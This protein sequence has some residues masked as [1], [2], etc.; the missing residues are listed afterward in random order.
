MS[1]PILATAVAAKDDAD[2]GGKSVELKTVKTMRKYRSQTLKD[3]QIMIEYKHLKHHAPRGMYVLPSFTDR[4]CWHGVVFLRQGLYKRGIFK[5]IVSGGKGA[6]EG[7]TRGRRVRGEWGLREVSGTG[8]GR[9]AGCARGLWAER[10]GR[11]R[12]GEVSLVKSDEM[13]R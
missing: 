13:G 2:E 3:Y 10:I 1:S 5:F 7:A 9:S 12:V 6:K 8:G 4:R 11:V